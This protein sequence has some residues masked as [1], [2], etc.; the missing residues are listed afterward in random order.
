ME[1]IW[2]SWI[3]QAFL[4]YLN[5]LGNAVVAKVH[6]RVATGLLQS[7]TVQYTYRFPWV[8]F[9]ASGRWLP[10]VPRTRRHVGWSPGHLAYPTC[11]LHAI[12]VWRNEI[13][14]ARDCLVPRDSSTCRLT[15]GVPRLVGLPSDVRVVSLSQ[16]ETLHRGI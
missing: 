14:G 5:Q 7:N 6:I 4:Y 8:E 1:F 9:G 12:P 2:L 15:S 16:N 3:Q 10:G 13:R 11:T